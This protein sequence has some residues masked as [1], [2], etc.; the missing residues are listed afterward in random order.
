MQKELEAIARHAGDII[1]RHGV[2][3][4]EQKEGHANFVTAVDR[5]VQDNLIDALSSLLPGSS[6]IGEEKENDMLGDDPTW[7]ID[8]VDGTTN[9][10]HDY[11]YS[12][13]SIALMRNRMPAIGV[14]YQPYTDELFYAE[15]GKG[16][17][18]NSKRIHVSDRSMD[19]ALV[20]FGTSPYHAELAE[21]SMDIALAYL[22]RAA[23]IRRSGSAAVDL[24]NVA[25]GRTD[26]FFEL[27]LKPW[28]FAAGALL[29]TEAG[30]HFT[31]PLCKAGVTF[32]GP[33]AVLAANDACLK[34]ATDILL[35][36]FKS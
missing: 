28:D 4:I 26:A 35:S 20:G 17:T 34:D 18:L 6:L 31:M 32:A 23:D 21:K 14:V 30:G 36:F 11:R 33:Q 5:A 3:R 9:L 24:A 25:C 15:L 29:I 1:L 7:I 12:A 27:Q 16:A 22:R 13:V 19:T 2:S 10:I 8:P